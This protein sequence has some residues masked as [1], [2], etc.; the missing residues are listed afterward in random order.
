MKDVTTHG[1]DARDPWFAEAEAFTDGHGQRDYDVAN[2]AQLPEDLED[3]SFEA[4]ED[5]SFSATLN[6]WFDYLNEGDDHVLM[7]AMEQSC[8]EGILLPWDMRAVRLKTLPDARLAQLHWIFR[9]CPPHVLAYL[10]LSAYWIVR[11]ERARR[12]GSP[13]WRPSM[14]K[15]PMT[16]GDMAPAFKPMRSWP[17]HWP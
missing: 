12:R 17:R 15:P 8:S 16:P 3:F 6:E 13:D 2:A 1:D 4:A 9:S 11:S 14:P 5:A 7:L 10:A